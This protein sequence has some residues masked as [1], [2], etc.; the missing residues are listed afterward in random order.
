MQTRDA[1]LIQWDSILCIFHH[2]AAND[3]VGEVE[4]SQS[5]HMWANH[6]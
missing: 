2:F 4:Y 6:S 1:P 3:G 5:P